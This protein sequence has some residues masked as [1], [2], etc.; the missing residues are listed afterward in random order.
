MNPPGGCADAQTASS[1]ISL[2]LGLHANVDPMKYIKHFRSIRCPNSNGLLNISSCPQAIANALHQFLEH[3]G[4]SEPNNT[5]SSEKTRITGKTNP[6]DKKRAQEVDI[7]CP[8]CGTLLRPEEGCWNC[9]K[10]AYSKCL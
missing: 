1:G 2:S 3:T 9:P 10:C 8:D 7:H 6:T 4:R 5:E